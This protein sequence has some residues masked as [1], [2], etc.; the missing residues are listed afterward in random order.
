MARPP[1]GEQL[2][3]LPHHIHG[4]LAHCIF[5]PAWPWQTDRIWGSQKACHGIG[6]QRLLVVGRR[7]M[8][9][10]SP[11]C[12]GQIIAA[13][14][15]SHHGQ[16]AGHGLLQRARGTFGPKGQHEQV[17]RK[18]QRR[19]RRPRAPWQPGKIGHQPRPARSTSARGRPSP[20]MTRRAVSRMAGSYLAGRHT[21]GMA[22]VG[23][24]RFAD[25]PPC[26]PAGCLRGSKGNQQAGGAPP[27]L[28][29]KCRY[30]RRWR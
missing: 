20:T 9:R 3:V 16:S 15:G 26:P 14:C 6:N 12:T 13:H 19:P 10:C 22:A 23:S 8:P 29:R 24:L 2:L 4:E 7:Q 5:L 28:V 11:S 25:G 27:A 1:G 30:P 18:A 17:K 21:E